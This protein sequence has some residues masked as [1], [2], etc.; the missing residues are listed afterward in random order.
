MFFLML[1]GVMPCSVVVGHLL[2]AAAVGFRDGAFH[3]AGHLVGI[4]DD[5]AIDVARGAADGLHQRGFGAQEAFLVGVENGDEGAFGN[6]E[7]FAQQVDADQHVEGAEAQVADDLDALQ[8]VDVRMHVAHADA[9]LVQVF[10]EVLGHALGERGD[11]GA[12]AGGGDLLDL[13]QQVVDLVARRADLDR[14]IDEAGRADDLLDEDAAGLLHLPFAA[15][16]PRRA[17]I[18][19]AWRPIPRSASGRLSMQEGRRKPYSASVALRRKSPR[20]MP[21][22]CG[23]V[24]W[25]SSVKTRALSGR[26]SNRVGGGS[27]GLRPV[28]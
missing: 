27:P 22:I 9:V 8:R 3:R 2:V 25:L 26:Y 6:V 16:S 7:A 19:A 13:A 18:A 28:R 24:T 20:Y 23:T 5:A 4:E 15:A 1:C 11:E 14:R 21:P 12:V 10:G 17:P